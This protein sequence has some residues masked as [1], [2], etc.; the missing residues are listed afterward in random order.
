VQDNV[1]KIR[2]RIVYIL[3]QECINQ[4][5]LAVETGAADA[6]D[7]DVGIYLESERPWQLTE[8]EDSENP[9]PLA[10][11]CLAGIKQPEKS[12]SMVSGK[13]F[14]AQFF[15]DC[16][17]CGNKSADGNNDQLASIRAW[18]TGRIIRNILMAACY[19]YLG[20]QMIVNQRNVTEMNA[21]TP[22]N[23]FTNTSALSITVCRIILEVN[24]T[25][26]SPQITPVEMEEIT[27]ISVSDNGEVLINM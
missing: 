26:N 7:F 17:G 13:K 14:I 5:A 19:T 20:M 21:G 18:K 8:Y 6:R 23:R 4:H 11:V 27:F 9:F 3:K 16:Y 12:G 1:E 15:I 10:N 25:E 24:Y 22:S 2:D